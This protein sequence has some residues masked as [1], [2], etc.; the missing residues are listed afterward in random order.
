MK[1]AFA[2]YSYILL[3]VLGSI[4][5]L[6]ALLV[7]FNDLSSEGWIAVVFMGVISIYFISYNYYLVWVHRRKTYYADAYA[8]INIGFSSLHGL[9]RTEQPSL[10]QML[11]GL[12]G[13]CNAVSTAFGKLYGGRIGVCIKFIVNDNGR[14]R[15][16]TLMRDQHSRTSGR[17][18]G[19]SD[20]TKH[21]IDA[22]SDFEFIYMNY[23][24]PNF[25]TSF[26]LERHLPT[27]QDYKNTRLDAK[28]FQKHRTFIFNNLHRRR[29]WPL[30]YKST[31]VTPIVPLIANEQKKAAIRGF[32]CVDSPTEGVFNDT[33]DV[34]I[35]K[36]ICDGLY[37]WIDLIYK[38]N[39]EKAHE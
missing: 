2:E 20:E 21:W 16:D 26:Y 8:D 10:E 24:D 34:D 17:M 39:K 32:F 28:W 23:E 14:P 27:C 33:Y 4:A 3:G 1:T 11:S 6:I 12:E 19:T 9:R 18:T 5:S 38:I 35:L 13:L 37:N 15:V 29:H 22:N 36:G 7:F 30:K 25:D 31:L